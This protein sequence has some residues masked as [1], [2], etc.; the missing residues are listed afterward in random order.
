MFD[1]VIGATS[2]VGCDRAVDS[3]LG[4]GHY[5]ELDA[6]FG[7]PVYGY[8]N[9]YANGNGYA[10]ANGNGNGLA[11]YGDPD[12]V[13]GPRNGG[14]RLVPKNLDCS[15][16]RLSPLGFPAT[17]LCPGACVSIS[18]QP[19]NVFKGRRLVIPSTIAVNLL[20]NDLK[21][22]SRSQFPVSNPVP[23]VVF[24]ENGVGVDLSLDTAQVSQFITLSVEN[25][26]GEILFV[27]A[28][29]GYNY[30]FC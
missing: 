1:D 30:D 15:T 19:Q 29:L 28:L 23:A 27:A 16:E 26:A 18:T 14:T 21:I 20:I 3:E 22:G 7:A 9:G 25:M 4:L 10:Y 24:Q 13:V 8:Q 2:F 17:T 6:V 5:S 11:T 12:I